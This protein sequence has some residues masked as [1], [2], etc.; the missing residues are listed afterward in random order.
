MNRLTYD[1]EYHAES[2]MHHTSA[3]NIM[4]TRLDIVII[5]HDEATAS[6]ISTDC[7]N[8]TLALETIISR[9]NPKSETSG[10]NSAEPLSMI[11]ISDRYRSL[12]DLSAD[13]CRRTYGRFDITLGQGSQF[14]YSD[15]GD[16]LIPRQ[17]L[18][19]DMGGIGKGI[20]VDEMTRIMRQA[21]TE[22]AFVSFGGSSIAA[23]GTHPAGDAWR[24][25]IADPFSGHTLRCIDLADTSISTSG[26]S[27]ALRGHII[28]P[29]TGY[30]VTG[31]R[32]SAVVVDSA[33]EAEALSTAW[34]VADSAMRAAITDNFDIKEEY[35]F[36]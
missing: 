23:I 19:I 11:S 35:V 1:T 34:L 7:L 33:T 26:N 17:G 32:L 8:A 30:A 24:V 12:L 4:G 14:A 31:R 13:M 20:A 27:S 22:R 3:V 21:G 28:D 10:I 2:R 36:N 9:Y 15:S 6:S 29:S 16:L 25:S 18:K 5:G